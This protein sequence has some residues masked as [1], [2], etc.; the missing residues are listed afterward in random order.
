[1]SPKAPDFAPSQE[2]YLFSQH[3]FGNTNPVAAAPQKSFEAR[4]LQKTK[5]CKYFPKGTCLAGDACNFAHGDDRQ[6]RPCFVFEHKRYCKFGNDCKF[7]H[8]LK[9]ESKAPKAVS[10]PRASRPVPE[11]VSETVPVENNGETEV[12]VAQTP[13]P[14]IVEASALVGGSSLHEALDCVSSSKFSVWMKQ[15]AKAFDSN[16][17][18][19]WF[20]MQ[21]SDDEDEHAERASL[22]QEFTSSTTKRKMSWNDLKYAPVEIGTNDV[23]VRRRWADIQDSEEGAE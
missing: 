15:E 8:R 4:L 17:A 19:S 16:S 13:I 3:Y 9:V 2:A 6:A 7:Q 14:E 11:V 12:E 5:R 18:N 20:N 10:R 22:A 21:D 23:A 1:V